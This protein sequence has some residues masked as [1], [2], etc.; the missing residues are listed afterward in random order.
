MVLY[1][2]WDSLATRSGVM[3]E[4]TLSSTIV[5]IHGRALNM[6]VMLP[7]MVVS[8]LAPPVIPILDGMFV[9]TPACCARLSSSRTTCLSVPPDISALVH[10]RERNEL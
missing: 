5:S 6:T 7:R 3:V 10:I 2:V 8:L 1:M 9:G 4:E